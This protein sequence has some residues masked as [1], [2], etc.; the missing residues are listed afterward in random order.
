MR[1]VKGARGLGMFSTWK[2]DEWY[3]ANITCAVNHGGEGFLWEALL[4]KRARISIAGAFVNRAE[5]KDIL[6]NCYVTL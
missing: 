5:T 6:E 1:T 3:T 4:G 2:L